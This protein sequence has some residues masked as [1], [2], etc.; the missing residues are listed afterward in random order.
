MTDVDFDEKV[1]YT[2]SNNVES[3]V[4]FISDEAGYDLINVACGNADAFIKVRLTQN[5]LKEPDNEDIPIELSTAGSYYAAS[6]VLLSLYNGEE[7]PSQFDIYYQKAEAMV[8]AYILQ[9][10]DLLAE[11]EEASKRSL[12]K[13]ARTQTYYQKRGTNRRRMRR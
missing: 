12:I 5:G 9:Q 6:D 7:L 13:H 11:T 8:D 10:K 4:K 2:D 3:L 1:T